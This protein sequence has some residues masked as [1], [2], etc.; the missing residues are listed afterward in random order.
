M[1]TILNGKVALVGALILMAG[2]ALGIGGASADESAKSAAKAADIINVQLIEGEGTAQVVIQAR[3]GVTHRASQLADPDR[4]VVDIIGAIYRADPTPQEG[5]GEL[6]RS[7]RSSQFSISPVPITRIVVDLAVPAVGRVMDVGG[8]LTIVLNEGSAVPESIDPPATE[9]PT[10]LGTALPMDHWQTSDQGNVAQPVR[11]ESDA[12]YARTFSLNVQNADIQTVLRS[13]AAFS[14]ENIISAPEVQGPVTA[15]L[16]DLPWNEALDGVLRANGFGYVQEHGVIRVDTLAKLREEQIAQKT[17]DQRIDQIEQLTTEVV[18]IDFANAEEVRDA[19]RNMVSTRGSVEVEP[20]TNSLVVNDIPSVVQMV[21]DL[22]RELDTRTPQVHIDATLLDVDTSIGEELGIKW[23][24]TKVKPDGLAGAGDATVDA[25]VTDPIGQFR[26]G[27]VP[28]WGE[29]QL[30]L[31]ALAKDNKAQIISNPAI[32]TTDNREAEILVGQKIPLIVADEAGNAITQ[33]TT[34]G[35]RLIVTP[36]INSDRQ[37]TLDVHPEVS[38]LSSQ[39][40]VQGGVIIN[41]SEADT[42]VLVN[43]GETAVIAGLIRDVD[44]RLENGVPVLKDVPVLGWLFKSTSTVSAKR[45]LI[46]FITPTIV[47]A[48]A[49]MI[50]DRESGIYKDLQDRK[51]AW[52]TQKV[53]R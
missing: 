27:W 31:Q 24:I 44:S 22:V 19:V 10:E 42:R 46:V 33:L 32:T 18:G 48:D 8:N 35:I 16:S 45:E 37:I 38:D 21:R 23:G 17:A 13:I 40:T 5:E 7:V 26:V 39:A 51:T 50:D 53:S 12:S 25:G 49:N 11:R 41:T 20:R 28:D 4:F 29:V 47:D 43:N 14:G 1:T 52:E 6:V 30:S 2:L 36:H 15:A 3:G 34:I 9:F